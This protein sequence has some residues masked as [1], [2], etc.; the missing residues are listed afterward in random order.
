MAHK[1][2]NQ[3]GISIIRVKGKLMGGPDTTAVHD[4]VKELIEGDNKKI[5]IDLSN[6]KWMN[7]TGLGV[8]MGAQTTARNHDADL[9][10]AGATDKVQS[11]FIITKLI[12]VFDTYDNVDQAVGSFL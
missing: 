1:I 8:L 10:L 7:S 12:T 9:K 6:V 3:K 5:I 4:H 2:E 11:L